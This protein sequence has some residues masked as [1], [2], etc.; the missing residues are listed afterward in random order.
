MPDIPQIGT[1]ELPNEEA[2][3]RLLGPRAWHYAFTH[4][5]DEVVLVLK[6]LSYLFAPPKRD[7]IY[8]YGNGWAGEFSGSVILTFYV[9]VA[10][11]APLLIVCILLALGL[12]GGEPA[13]WVA[14][15]L[16]GLGLAP[17]MISIGDS[18][19]LMPLYP[20][21]AF[22]AGSLL[23]PAPLSGGMSRLVAAFLLVLFSVNAFLDLWVTQSA[24]D[25]VMKPGG[26]QLF[27]PYHFAR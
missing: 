7:L 26:S 3:A 16:V 20:L 18:R 1:A 22:A 2:R 23:R 19:F 15:L 21:L 9:W 24:L 27:P 13:Y 14:L 12:K 11:S 4:P 17:Y 6:R 8:I 25:A 5:I 10:S